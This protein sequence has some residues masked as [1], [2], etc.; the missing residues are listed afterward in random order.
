MR[1]AQ[2]GLLMLLMAACQEPA[3]QPLTLEQL[4]F[5]DPGRDAIAANGIRQVTGRVSS[6][7][8]FQG[9]T[10]SLHYYDSLGNTLYHESISFM[11]PKTN[12]WYNSLGLVV[13]E[14][15]FTDFSEEI[16]Y[17]YSYV[18]EER[19][20][21][22]NRCHVGYMVYTQIW[23]FNE[24][25]KP[26]ATFNASE[27]ERIAY[28]SLGRMSMRTI[29]IDTSF[30][31]EYDKWKIPYSRV[32]H[33]QYHVSTNLLSKV[34]HLLLNKQGE[35]IEGGMIATYTSKGLPYQLQYNDSTIIQYEL[36]TETEWKRTASLPQ[37]P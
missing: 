1:L 28:D 21:F 26:I 15:V 11:G 31:E 22:E 14:S 3:P 36:Y 23:Q 13:A 30:F 7:G 18:P 16:V 17:S 29:T 24:D 12:A 5:P 33:Y 2:I 6:S 8:H 10:V 35:A 27:M 19:T 37:I 32:S 9:D 34:E 4:Q 25:G 20:L